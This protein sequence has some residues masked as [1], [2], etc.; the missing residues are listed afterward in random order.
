M[1]YG[2][3]KMKTAHCQ[4]YDLP[5][6]LVQRVEN[7]L[8]KPSAASLAATSTWML[9]SLGSEK[10]RLE[11]LDREVFLSMYADKLPGC[12]YCLVCRRIH[13]STPDYKESWHRHWAYQCTYLADEQI[14]KLAIGWFHWVAP[15]RVRSRENP[16]ISIA[17][18]YLLH[19]KHVQLTMERHRNA[20]DT[21]A[22]L[23]RFRYVS[24]VD[25]DPTRGRFWKQDVAAR[26]V[27]GELLFRKTVRLDPLSQTS[28]VW[29][30]T[31]LR[32][33]PGG[34]CDPPAYSPDAFELHQGLRRCAYCH[35]DFP[36]WQTS[37]GHIE[38][39][40]WY[41]FG[42]GGATPDEKFRAHCT[43]W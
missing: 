22:D 27:Q 25:D 42:A 21:S 10:L 3:Y 39:T 30:C 19:W 35:T 31:H 2:I 36:L 29:I 5:L 23:E 40:A 41:S 32:Y 17:H 14:E 7:H 16:N 20:V 4:F 34:G 43:T 18:G 8:P 11:G 37:D 12:N 9:Y 13:P 38:L 33:W 28:D 15:L 1:I 26:I 24:W 6:E